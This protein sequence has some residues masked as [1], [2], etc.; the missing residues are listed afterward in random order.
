MK[1]LP[2]M[3]A[4]LY[5][6]TLL[7]ATSVKEITTMK[8]YNL[9]AKEKKPVVLLFYAPW[10]GA[11]E[12]IKAPYEEVASEL[13]DTILMVKLDVDKFKPLVRSLGINAIPTIYIRKAGKLERKQN[14]QQAIDAVK[15]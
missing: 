11:C 9:L 1:R 6:A 12:K 4:V 10:C 2:L 7:G 5:G 13:K 3:L 15:S 14:L 8:E